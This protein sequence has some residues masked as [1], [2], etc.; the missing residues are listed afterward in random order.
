MGGVC[1]TGRMNIVV[2]ISVIL[3]DDSTGKGGNCLA[4][5]DKGH[6]RYLRLF[7]MIW[8]RDQYNLKTSTTTMPNRRDGIRDEGCIQQI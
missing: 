3:F 2:K 6:I 8:L 7:D 4:E 1:D 5:C